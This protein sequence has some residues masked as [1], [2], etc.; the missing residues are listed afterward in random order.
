MT[1]RATVTDHALVRWLERVHGLDLDSVRREIEAIA[2][3]A[4]A[5]GAVSVSHG[6]FT[7]MISSFGAV[8]T[9]VEGTGRT[10][11]HLR[12]LQK[13]GHNVRLRTPKHWHNTRRPRV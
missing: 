7:L 6:G 1:T 8:T 11:A 4:V 5:A 12:G 13:S 2:T 3:P 10:G 9:V